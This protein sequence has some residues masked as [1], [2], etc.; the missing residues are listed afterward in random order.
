MYRSMNPSLVFV[1]VYIYVCACLLSVFVTCTHGVCCS[2]LP[3]CM[4]ACMRRWLL[5]CRTDD[6][7][8]RRILNAVHDEDTWRA[9]SCERAFLAGLD[10]DCRSP[11]AA[12]AVTVESSA[13]VGRGEMWLRGLVASPDGVTVERIEARGSSATSRQSETLGTE[14]AERLRQRVGQ[15]FLK[16]IK[17]R[18]PGGSI[19]G[20]GGSVWRG[21]Q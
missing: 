15:A 8:V 11:I 2:S 9:V 10:G 21:Q 16:A 12:H 6:S 5:Q 13:G 3:A 1:R 19:A 14:T 17:G 7:T 4:H 18:H 20:G